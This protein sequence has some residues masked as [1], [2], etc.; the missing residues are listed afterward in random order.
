[1]GTWVGPDTVAS[2]EVDLRG[3]RSDEAELALAR[4]VDAAVLDGL[5]Q[6]RI[7]HGK[8]TGALRLRVSEALKAD[9]RVSSHRLG[10]TGEGG[11]GVTVAVLR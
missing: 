11:A 7:I 10:Q 4:A 9:S 8:G 2:P 5:S 1:L 6:L 3:M